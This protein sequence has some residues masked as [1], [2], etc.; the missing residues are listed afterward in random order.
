MIAV[1]A[2][3]K[4]NIRIAVLISGSGSNLQALIDACTDSDYPAEIAVVLSNKPDAFGLERAEAAGIPGVIVDHKDFQSRE[5]FDAALLAALSPYSV[6]LV[7][8]AGF[9]RILTPVFIGA[10][11][12][13]IL[14]THPSLLP[15]HGGEGMFGA[16]VHAS[17]LAAGDDKSGVSIHEVT[18]GVD[19]GP[20][21]LQRQVPVLDDDTPETLGARVLREEHIAYPEAVRIWAEKTLALRP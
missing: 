15:K 5:D 11:A 16:H 19:Q 7:C 18:Q 1:K 10:F 4:S 9:M 6:D 2:V 3:Q 13:R 12:G 21:V 8:L 17:V 14:N 20:V